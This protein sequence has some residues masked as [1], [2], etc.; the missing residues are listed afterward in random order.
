MSCKPASDDAGLSHLG[1]RNP[2]ALSPYHKF[3]S[4]IVRQTGCQQRLIEHTLPTTSR[5][6]RGRLALL[7]RN[8]L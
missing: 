4:L 5:T 2:G 1:A 7:A 6:G 8:G 3:H